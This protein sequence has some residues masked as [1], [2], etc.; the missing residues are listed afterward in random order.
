[1]T[2]KSWLGGSSDDDKAQAP[3]Q[4]DDATQRQAQSTTT[5]QQPRGGDGG[6]GDVAFRSTIDDARSIETDDGSVNPHNEAMAQKPVAIPLNQTEDQQHATGSTGDLKAKFRAWG[7]RLRLGGPSGADW[8]E[9]ERLTGDRPELPKP[10]EPAP[11]VP[12]GAQSAVPEGAVSATTG[13]R[14]AT[15]SAKPS[16]D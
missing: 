6:G 4:T 8:E 7:R 15:T 11:S 2:K 1:M 3:Q 16:R 14:A 5:Q 12:E 13:Q 9:F 10:P